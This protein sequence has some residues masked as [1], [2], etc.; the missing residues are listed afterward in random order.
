M[1]VTSKIIAAVVGGLGAAVLTSDPATA[2]DLFKGKTIKYIVATAAGGGYDGYGR[3]TARYMEKYLP[4]STFAVINR[5]GA[6]HIIGTNLIYAARPNG[7]TIGTFNTGVIYS[8][9]LKLKAAR[10]DLSKMSWIGKAASAKR[11]IVVSTLTPYKTFLD[12]QKAKAPIPMAVSGVGSAAYTELRLLANV[13]DFKFKLLPG[14]SGGDDDMAMMRGEVVGKMGSMSGQGD[15]VRAGKGRYVLQVGGARDTRYPDMAFGDDIAKTPEQ[16]AVI[17]LVGS[18]AEMFRVT[19]GPPNIPKDRLAA[20]REAYGKAF[21]DPQLRADAKKL[22]W[23][24]TPLVGA[25]VGEEIS[26]GLKQPPAIIAMLKD[27]QKSKPSAMKV[28]VKLTATKRGGREIQFKTAKGED[29][30]TKI[31]GSRTTVKIAGKASKRGS[32]K[33]GMACEVTYRGPGTE[34]ILVDCK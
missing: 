28:S 27:L 7:Q 12:F 29:D 4:G 23:D 26:A 34:A 5:P 24:I 2:S 21:D 20:L 19:A 15:F 9:I 30:K 3:L 1:T 11:T 16:K 32:L 6:G 18:Q 22:R 33:S 17:K 8:Q 25:K 10:Y 31:S 13:F 14:Y